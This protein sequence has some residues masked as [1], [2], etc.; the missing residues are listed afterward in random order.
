[1]DLLNHTLFRA[2]ELLL[3]P[4]AYWPLG[5]LIACS[6]IAG[7]VMAIMF[8]VTSNQQAIGRAADGCRAEVLAIKLF[9]DDLVGV[10]K[11]CG[12]LLRHAG[13][14]IG[15]SVP[16]MLVMVIPLILLFSQLALWYEREPL[17]TG[18][19]VVVQL[20][21]ASGQWRQ[22]QHAQLKLPLGTTLDAGPL[23]DVGQHA[24]FWRLKQSAPVDSGAQPQR[25]QWDVAGVIVEKHLTTATDGGQRL[26]PV[27]ARRAG[28][29]WLDQIL[30][31]G[32]PGLPRG[33]SVRGIVV[34]Y[35]HRETPLFGWAIPWWLTFLIVSMLSAVAVKPLVGVR[36]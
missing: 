9:Q 8:R 21:I 16:P 6:A 35:P 14:R 24:I 20:R 34:H 27:N 3:A 7:I 19:S 36:F 22:A 12:R 31:S 2:C 28:P 23:R 17:I 10:M 30:H 32:E 4:I 11:S 15:H 13:A 29:G 25:L 18:N 33:G 1:M 5:A 26:R